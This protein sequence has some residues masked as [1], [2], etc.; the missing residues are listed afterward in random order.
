MKLLLLT[1]FLVS[2]TA[3]AVPAEEFRFA[4]ESAIKQV[5]ATVCHLSWNASPQE[6]EVVSYL[7]Y[8]AEAITGPFEAVAQ[9]DAT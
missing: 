4:E 3:V 1:L 9:T 2:S 5:S 6:F 8:Q 7:I